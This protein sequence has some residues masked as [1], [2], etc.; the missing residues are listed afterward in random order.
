MS[1][2]KVV[3]IADGCVP[4]PLEMQ[5]EVGFKPLQPVIVRAEGERL[6]VE[7]PS[8]QDL[9]AEISRLC[10]ELR[11]GEPLQQIWAEIEEGREDTR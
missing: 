9:A 5:K 1:A 4:I 6:I 3:M 10:A 11:S 2:A 8:R 7:K